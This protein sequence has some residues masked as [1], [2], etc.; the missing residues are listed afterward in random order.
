[1]FPP[2]NFVSDFSEI[3]KYFMTNYYIDFFYPVTVH[4]TQV[5]EF[6]I[7]SIFSHLYIG[8]SAS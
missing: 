1:M 7:N 3:P 8:F 2:S 5:M 4:I 6:A